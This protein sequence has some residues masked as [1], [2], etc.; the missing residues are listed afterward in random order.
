MNWGSEL[1]AELGSRFWDN[2][3]L[4]GLEVVD[5]IGYVWGGRAVRLGS[6]EK[7]CL[8]G[9]VCWT[10]MMERADFWSSRVGAAANRHVVLILA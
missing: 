2:S 8:Q 10:R 7:F 4:L 1:R 3:G 5:N 9:P 6:F